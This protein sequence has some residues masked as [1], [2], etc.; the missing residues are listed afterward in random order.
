MKNGIRGENKGKFRKK[1]TRWNL[2]SNNN[3]LNNKNN[4]LAGEIK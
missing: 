3:P 4:S 1:N 2:Y